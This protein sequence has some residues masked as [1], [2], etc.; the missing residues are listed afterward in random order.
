M[1]ATQG[2]RQRERSVHPVRSNKPR[3]VAPQPKSGHPA[4]LAPVR[5]W[6]LSTFY[7]AAECISAV[8]MLAASILTT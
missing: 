1:Q 4:R 8:L 3:H 6:M 5:H 7:L 2:R